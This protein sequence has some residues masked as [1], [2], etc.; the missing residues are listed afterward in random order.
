M[1]RGFIVSPRSK[2]A[3]RATAHRLLDAFP[4]G[5]R[6]VPVLQLLEV[7]MPSI[8]EDFSFEIL[9]SAEMF[10]RFGQ[11]AEGITC[12]KENMIALRTDV[13][14]R[15]AKGV[16]RDRFTAAHE[17][18][19]YFLHA[20]EAQT[21]MRQSSF[22]TKAYCDSEWQANQFARELLADI[23]HVGRFPTMDAIAAH[24]GVSYEVARIQFQEAKK[25]TLGRA[26]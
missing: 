3:I 14:E 4:L 10:Q 8:E 24:Y 26:I 16:G 20:N 21:M 12:H 13:Y 6:K 19:H 11:D 9:D 17:L 18:G 7:W 15:A 25:M 22:D 23:R 5:G 1:H 2:Q